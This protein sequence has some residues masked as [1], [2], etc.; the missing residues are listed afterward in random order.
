MNLAPRQRLVPDENHSAVGHGGIG[1]VYRARDMPLGRGVAIKA[2]H[3]QFNERV[4]R[5]ARTISSPHSSADSPEMRT[6]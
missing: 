3:H 1:E 6:P 2:S 4:D 5:E